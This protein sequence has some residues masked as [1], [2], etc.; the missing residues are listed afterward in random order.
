MRVSVVCFGAM[1]EFLPEGAAGNRA[2]VEV[3]AGAGAGD[4]VDVL[5]APRRLVFALL[6]DGEQASLDARLHEGAEVTLMPPFAG[7]RGSRRIGTAER[8]GTWTEPGPRQ[9]GC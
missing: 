5:G 6:V 4:L 2:E 8:S 1:R 7:G 9:A 3:E